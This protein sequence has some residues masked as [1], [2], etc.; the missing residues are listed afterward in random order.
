MKQKKGI[1]L[2]MLAVL[3]VIMSILAA[4]I[5]TSVLTSINN[6]KLS[7]W[8][9]EITYVQDI[10]NET[11]NKEEALLNEINFS[12]ENIDEDVR[13]EQFKDENIVDNVITLYSVNLAKIGL[14]N[15]V[16]GK[17]EKGND[18]YAYSKTT[19]KVYY[20]AGMKQSSNEV[21]YTLTDELKNKY[22]EQADETGNASHVVFQ[23][24]S[25]V[26]TTSPVKVLVRVP[27]KYTNISVTTNNTSIAVGSRTTNGKMYEYQVNTTNV[28]TNYRVIVKYNDGTQSKMDIYDVDVYTGS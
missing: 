21:Y 18:I 12:V 27:A 9:Q 6:A 16:Y 22:N 25:V 11:T 3:V 10:M 23:P 7:I 19:G 26:S 1:T 8:S 5:T 14:D 28:G 13:N 2:A 24:S 20:L 15:T 4:T 17:Y